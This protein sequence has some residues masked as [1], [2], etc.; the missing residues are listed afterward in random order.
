[1]DDPT[2]PSSEGTKFAIPSGHILDKI[3]HAM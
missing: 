3:F 1:M 2:V